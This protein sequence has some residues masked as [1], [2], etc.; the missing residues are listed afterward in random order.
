MDKHLQL[1]SLMFLYH[2]SDLHIDS[3]EKFSKFVLRNFF[4]RTYFQAQITIPVTSSFQGSIKRKIE[5]LL[6]MIGERWNVDH[7]SSI[8][9]VLSTD[10]ERKRLHKCPW[11][12]HN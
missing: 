2:C 9:P 1:R 6:T 8:I 4:T 5:W 3:V 7:N 11:H 10:P 12:L